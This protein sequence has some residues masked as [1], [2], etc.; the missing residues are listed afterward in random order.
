MSSD[1]YVRNV[2]H[3]YEKYKDVIDDMEIISE[4]ILQPLIFA[5]HFAAEIER[6]NLK[7]RFTLC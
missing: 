6:D 1:T 2:I 4:P 5:I 3:I 7:S